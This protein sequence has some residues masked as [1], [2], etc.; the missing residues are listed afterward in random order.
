MSLTLVTAPTTEPLS[1]AAAKS[2]L[3]MDEDEDD[4]LIRSLITAAR[5]W[6]EGQTHRALVSQ[7]W[8]QSID[9]NWPWKYGRPCI[10]LEKNPILSVDSIT[11]VSGASPEPT[12]G[13]SLYT[14]VTRNN[15]SYV[16]PAYGQTWPSVLCVPNAITVRFTAGYAT[17]PQPLVHAITMLVAHW[18]ENREVIAMKE[19]YVVP[20]TIEALISPY[21][22][23]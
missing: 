18:Y 22:G 3:R 23:N 4:A 10:E 14:A 9:G 12:L 21:R 1:L 19:P 7:I 5:Q 2:Q 17:V 6:V 20:F 16:V 13:T 15:G 11:Y 8:D